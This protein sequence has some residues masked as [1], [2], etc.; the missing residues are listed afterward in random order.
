M[1]KRVLTF[2]LKTDL[3]WTGVLGSVKASFK[4]IVWASCSVSFRIDGGEKTM[5]WSPIRDLLC[6]QTSNIQINISFYKMNINNII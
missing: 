2:D 3:S 5:L 1:W 6:K 4:L